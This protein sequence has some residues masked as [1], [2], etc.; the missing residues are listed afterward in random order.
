MA[1]TPD[2]LRD[3]PL[4]SLLDEDELAVIAGQVE[5]ARFEPRQRIYR[6]GEVGLRA[7]VLLSGS[8]SVTTVDEDGQEVLIA[9][10]GHGELFGFASMLEQTPHHTTAVAL[11]AS[12]CVEVDRNDITVLLMKKPM[13]GL[14]MMSVMA[15][16]FHASQELVRLRAARNPNVVIEEEETRGERIAD[17]VASF[18]GSWTFIIAFAV[19]LTIYTMTNVVLKGRAWDPYPFILLN[20]FLSMLAAI[21]APVIM[22]S[23]N[24]QDKKDRLRSE[25]D[26]DV[27]VRA[28]SE[29]QALSRRLL[30][31][32]E[33]LD[34]VSD[35]LRSRKKD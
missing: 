16:Q 35:A 4:F 26:F 2:E 30:E 10:P 11:E 34:D 21:Q 29:I 32:H 28:E 33:T 27:N 5:M 13:A 6:R 22:M 1:S 7:Y 14:D 24:R 20:L 3:V 15:R 12:V 8:V 19:V 18:G 31:L 9:Q 25:L 17:K 23:Q